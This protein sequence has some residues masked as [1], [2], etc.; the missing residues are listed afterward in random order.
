MTAAGHF[1][2]RVAVYGAGTIAR[3]VQDY[4]T[5]AAAGIHF[6]AAFDDRN[7]PGR[8]DDEGLTI[9]GNLEDLIKAGRNDAID[10]IIIALPPGAEYR[11][12]HIITQLQQ[13]PVSIH[14]VTHLATDLIDNV[15]NHK[16]SAIGPVGMID[17][18]NKP[19]SDWAPILKQVEDYVLGAALSVLA[20]PLCLLI[21]LAIRLEGSGPILFAQRRHGLNKRVVNIYKFRTMS[22]MEDGPTVT[23]ATPNDHRITCVGSALRR[24]SLDELPQLLNVLKGEM[25]LVGPRP[26]ALVHDE[27]WSEMLETYA[28]RHQV[29][30]GI[31]GLAQ[32]QGLR[33]EIDTPEKIKERIESD[34]YYIQNW[35]LWLDMKI[36]ARTIGAVLTA[37]NAH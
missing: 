16:V 2:T 12:A 28:N 36:L 21:A 9:H 13:L 17:V 22:V 33:G 19:L 6:V 15:L 24:T 5:S 25:S 30:P 32:I 8:I 18:K 31:T 27:Q 20:L 37:K 7:E 4:L 14:I 35:S 11:M 3:R 34:L 26:H 1:D 10:Q 29:K 23:Q